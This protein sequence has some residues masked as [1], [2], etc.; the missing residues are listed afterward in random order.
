MEGFGHDESREYAAAGETRWIVGDVGQGD[1][2]FLGD[3]VPS[4]VVNGPTDFSA[5]LL[6]D[7]NGRKRPRRVRF[8]HDPLSIRRSICCHKGSS[9][10]GFSGRCFLLIRVV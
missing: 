5:V 7:C 4:Q 8:F 1:G 2:V 9:I 3:G 10:T 6:W